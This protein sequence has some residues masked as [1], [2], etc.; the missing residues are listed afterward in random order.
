MFRKSFDP[1][2]P[3]WLFLAGYAQVYVVQAISYREYAL[4]R[5]GLEVVTAANFRALWALAWFLLV[6]HCGARA[7]LAARLP[8]PPAAWSAPLVWRLAPILI[9]WGLICAGFELNSDPNE[10]MTAEETLLPPVP[11][12]DARGRHPPDRDRPQ[13][14]PPSA[15]VDVRSAWRS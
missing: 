2:A 8:R 3:V 10:V 6:Y 7:G 11:D 15:G 12:P 5:A 4:G 13:R 1:F 14:P 9:A